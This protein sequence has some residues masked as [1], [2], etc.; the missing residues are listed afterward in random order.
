MLFKGKQNLHNTEENQIIV[1]CNCGTHLIKI[2]S[3]DDEPETF[4]EI[5]VS[6]F[7]TKQKE[8]LYLR[9]WHRLKLIWYAIRGK[10]YRLEDFVLDKNDVEELIKALQEIN[11]N[12]QEVK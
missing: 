2:T 12:N 7:Y 9:I 5:W 6:N 10:E 1:E 8:S 3:F 11:C 4:F